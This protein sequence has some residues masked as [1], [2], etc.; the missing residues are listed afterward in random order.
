MRNFLLIFSSF[1]LFNTLTVS[2]FELPDKPAALVNDYSNTLSSSD[3]S[4]LNGKLMAYMDSTSTQIFIVLLNDDEGKP[5]ELMGAEIGEKWGV[6]Q[7]GKDNGVVVLMYPEERKVTI[8]TGYGLE[9]FIPDALA[10]RIIENEMIPSFRENNFAE[11]L[12]KGTN[13]IMNLLS[14]KFTADQYKKQSSSSGSPIGILMLIILFFIFFGQSRKRRFGSV[15]RNLPLWLAL[16]MLGGRGNSHNGSWGGFSSG[17]GG[18]GFS[19]G[20]G[21]SFGG[22]GASGSW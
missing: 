15:G 21:G 19:G 4:R 7:K 10:K 3:V 20:G 14:G 17:S 8:Q 11:G 6:G 5:I 9:E 2:A 22:G 1:L 13:V 16:S 18:G 12:D